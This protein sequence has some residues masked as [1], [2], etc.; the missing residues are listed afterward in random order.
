[1]EEHFSSRADIHDEEEF[2]LALETPVQLDYEWVVKLLHNVPLIDDRLDLLLPGELVLAHDLHSIESARVLLPHEDHSAEGSS[3]Y[4]FDLLEVMPAHFLVQLC[5]LGE[6]ELCKVCP[7]EFSILKYADGSVVLGEPEV[8]TLSN[9]KGLQGDDELFL[10]LYLLVDYTHSLFP[11]VP[12]DIMNYFQVL[13]RV[14]LV[15]LRRISLWTFS[16]VLGVLPL[17]CLLL[18]HLVVSPDDL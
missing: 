5:V 3:P 1:M 17:D 16:C 2:G 15:D 8:E 13:V 9:I 12:S 18:E 11:S 10:Q 14:L 7:Q 4:H 6:V